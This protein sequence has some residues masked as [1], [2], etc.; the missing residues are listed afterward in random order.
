MELF[1]LK[2]RAQRFFFPKTHVKFPFVQKLAKET[3][4]RTTDQRDMER[5][6]ERLKKT[7]QRCRSASLKLQ[8]YRWRFTD[9]ELCEY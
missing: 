1:Q 9:F 3:P 8:A 2:N 7:Q 4:Y 5:D 6:T